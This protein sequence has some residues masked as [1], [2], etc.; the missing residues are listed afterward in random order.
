MI[1]P[2]GCQF[3]YI[4]SFDATVS[5]TEASSSY[6][7]TASSKL[8]TSQMNKIPPKGWTNSPLYPN[9]YSPNSDCLYIFTP[10]TDYLVDQSI[11][12]VFETFTTAHRLQMKDVFDFLEI[13]QLYIPLKEEV[14]SAL[15]SRVNYPSTLERSYEA[16]IQRWHNLE[17]ELQIYLGTNQHILEPT[18]VYCGSYVP[19][20]VV[21]D[22]SATAI[23]M[24]F[25]SGQNTTSKGFTLTYEFLPK[26]LLNPVKSNVADKP[27]S[28]NNNKAKQMNKY[29]A[30]GLITSPNYPNSYTNDC[31]RA[32]LRIYE[33]HNPRSLY[34]FCGNPSELSSIIISNPVARVKMHT[35]TDASGSK[36][37]ELVWT[38]LLPNDPEIG[39]KG[40]LCEHTSHCIYNDLECDEI[41]N[42]GM[43]QKNGKWVKDESDETTNCSFGNSY[44]LAHIGTGILLA[45]IFLLSIACY[46]YYH[47][48]KRRKNMPLDPLTE[49]TGS[50]HS[51]ALNQSTQKL[52][53]HCSNKKHQ[54]HKH[55][56]CQT[57]GLLC[58]LLT[59]KETDVSSV[60]KHQHHRHHYPHAQ[61]LSHSHQIPSHTHP[62]RHHHHHN[63]NR[64]VFE[65]GGHSHLVNAQHDYHGA[66]F[67]LDNQHDHCRTNRMS[68][69][70]Q[71]RTPSHSGSLVRNGGR[72]VVPDSL[73]SSAANNPG[74]LLVAGT[75]TNLSTSMDGGLLIRERMQKISIV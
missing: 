20:P 58:D 2:G 41:P 35:A 15:T 74:G 17:K 26:A 70:L 39:C 32:V 64:K 1:N 48:Y 55:H 3:L 31:S 5:T 42:C 52:N 33:G 34:E 73:H 72:T 47:E 38:D 51:L 9:D 63:H 7:S 36:G 6:S 25:H 49:L 11:R 8:F 21:S 14:M 13:I 22:T 60:K 75:G 19:G 43:Y 23:L 65:Q 61:H 53:A 66:H 37:F 18:S 40:F 28:D 54:L 50:K 30:G 59:E 57:S 24:R 69:K 16:W 62:H 4:N 67:P 27:A 44:N 68:N 46:V 71:Q 12:L 45:L 29:V 56:N 10:Q